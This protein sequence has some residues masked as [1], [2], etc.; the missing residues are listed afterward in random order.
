MINPLPLESA[1][2]KEPALRSSRNDLFRAT[3]AIFIVACAL[4]PGGTRAATLTFT[5]SSDANI[6]NGVLNSFSTAAYGLVVNTFSGTVPVME[7]NVASLPTNILVDAMTFN[8]YVTSYTG[9]TNPINIMA[10][11]DNGVITSSDAS[12]SATTLGT[13]NPVSL[14]LGVHSIGLSTSFLQ[15]HPGASYLALR[16]QSSTG[17]ANTQIGSIEQ[18][19]GFAPLRLDIT[20][21]PVPEP[22]VTPLVAA[23]LFFRRRRTQRVR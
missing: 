18:Q 2:G 22:A 19:P 1:T 6:T 8:F 15:S 23:V 3:A 16:L 11:L 9:S 12:A 10:F 5:A 13:Y 14:G 21:H 20:F 17:S 4:I 7:F